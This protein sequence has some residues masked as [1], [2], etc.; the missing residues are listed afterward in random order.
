MI[1]DC[2]LSDLERIAIEHFFFI[3]LS[4]LELGKQMLQNVCNIYRFPNIL[5]YNIQWGNKENVA[6][7]KDLLSR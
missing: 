6:V 2:E 5:N 1:K 3:W 7:Y 4:Y